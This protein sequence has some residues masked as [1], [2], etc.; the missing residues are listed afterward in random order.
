MDN[1]FPNGL[2]PITGNSLGLD[3]NAG[4]AIAGFPRNQ[5]NSY[6]QQ[7]SID[8]QRQLPSNFVLT[9]GY[10]GNSA[11]HLYVPYNYD[12]LPDRDLAMGSALTATVPNPFYGAI[13]TQTSAL[14]K[15]TVRAF[16]LLLP[17]PQFTTMTS[18]VAASP[19]MKHC[20]FPWNIVFRRDCLCWLHIPTAK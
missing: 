3:T 10:V 4:L 9:V 17:H 14:S 18:T 15:P 19:P 7:W 1:P 2:Q 13:T 5:I 8:I 6:S 11:V 12:Q 16:Q 20:N